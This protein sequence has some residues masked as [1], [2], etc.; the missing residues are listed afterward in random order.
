M[1]LPDSAEI[2]IVGAGIS[3]LATALPLARAGRE[4]VVLDA[5]T[6]WADASGA[7]AGTLSV[8]VKRREVLALTR[9][10]IRLW[11][12]LPEEYGID[13]GFARPGGLRVATSSHEVERLKLAVTE[14]R[15]AGIEVDFLD[16][17]AA[18]ARAPWLSETVMAASHCKWDG[19]SSPLVAGPALAAGARRLGVRIEDRARVTAIRAGTG[20]RGAYLLETTR[21]AIG[22]GDVVIAAGA[23][24]GAVAGLVGA[25]F[26]MQ[27]DVNMLTVTEPSPPLLDHVVTH[28]GGILSLKQHRNGTCLIGGGWQGRGDV[29]AGT[30]E[31]DHERLVHN[32]R[33][34]VGVVPALGDMLMVRTWAGYESVAPDALPVLGRLAGHERAWVIACARGGYSQGPAL[35]AR[36]AAMIMGCEEAPDTLSFSPRRFAQ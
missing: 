28:V 26:P 1:S 11:E 7:N 5:A 33:I 25:E 30:R 8:Q 19:W 35:G 9:E 32:M 27:V 20:G 21:G 29:A 6:P 12:R 10:S 31:V 34:A 4:V 16:G 15:A 24:A 36:L 23:W 17:A 18:H 2:V 3:G 14:Q 13:V 22:A